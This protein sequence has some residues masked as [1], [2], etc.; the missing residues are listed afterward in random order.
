MNTLRDTN[1]LITELTTIDNYLLLIDTDMDNV[2]HGDVALYIHSDGEEIITVDN[3]YLGDLYRIVAHLPNETKCE[4]KG[5]PFLPPLPTL[6]YDDDDLLFMFSWAL[7]NSKKYN[8][9]FSIEK[10]KVFDDIW[11]S[12]KKSLDKQKRPKNFIVEFENSNI[13]LP[14]YNQFN[15]D[16]Q[17]YVDNGNYLRPT[18]KEEF[19][20]WGKTSVPLVINNKIQGHYE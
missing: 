5:A 14:T 2:K 13:H 18:T 4:I 19:E 20:S 11:L 1:K 8:N 3:T 15:G 7:S 9:I 10:N 17:K 6:V 16:Y 12:G